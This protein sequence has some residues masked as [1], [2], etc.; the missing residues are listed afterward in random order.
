VPSY[1]HGILCKTDSRYIRQREFATKHLPKDPLFQL[2]SRVFDVWPFVLNDLGEAT[3][4]H[5]WL[6]VNAHSS[7]LLQVCGFLGS[8]N[9]NDYCNTPF[10]CI[11][12]LF[13][14]IVLQHFGLTETNYYA[15]LFGVS[16]ALGTLASLVWDRGL[17]L[18]IEHPISVSTKTAK[19]LVDKC[20]VNAN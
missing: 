13:L 14:N 20:R 8:L 4:H 15:V 18:P 16:R 12:V 11:Y 3:N 19:E 2:L 1:R 17:G 5:Q 7:V 6:S 10:I 9:S